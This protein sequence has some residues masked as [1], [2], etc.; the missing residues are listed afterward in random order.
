MS[1]R[2]EDRG[3]KRER[4][5]LLFQMAALL[6]LHGASDSFAQTT[7]DTQ[8]PAPSKEQPVEE[9]V[10]TGFRAGV[11]APSPSAFTSRIEFDDYQGERT[12][13]T[14]LL[15]EQVGVQV[16]RF[17][18]PGDPAEVSIRGSTGAQVVVK[19]D[20]VRMNSVLTGGTDV[21]QLCLGLLE[22]A[23]ITRGGDPIRAGDGSIGGSISFQTRRPSPETVN[24]V[25]VSGGAFGTWE[26]DVQRS[27]QAGPVEY[28]VGYCGFVSDGDYRFAR[29]EIQNPSVP[30][31]P[32]PDLIRINNHRSRQSGNLSL[33][34]DIGPGHLR[35]QDYLTYTSHGVPGLDSGDGPLGGQNP[36]AHAW[37]THNLA[38]LVYSVDDLGGWGNGFEGS[39]HH[40]YQRFAFDDPGVTATDTPRSILTE[41]QTLGAD[42]ENHW[43]FEIWNSSLDWTVIGDFR[44]DMLTD[45]NAPDRARNLGGLATEIE[46]GWL[47]DRIIL[48]PGVRLEWVEGFGETWL[49]TL[50]LVLA[51]LPWLRIKGNLQKTF[52]AP[53]FDELYLPDQ[54]FIRGNPNLQPERAQNADAG[55][56]ARVSQLGPFSDLR[57][58]GGVFLQEVD[59]SILWVNVSPRTIEPFNTGRAQVRGYEISLSFAWTRFFS[60]TANHTGQDAILESTGRPLPGRAQS[61]SL[62]RVRVGEKGR[63]KLIGEMN[64]TGKI[65]VS[66]SGAILLPER[67]VWSASAA[68]NCAEVFPAGWRPPVEALWLYATLNNIS[69]IAV[70]D[71]LFF[72]QPGRNGYLGAQITW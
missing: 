39:L 38:R 53:S 5:R 64:R 23:E 65:P 2:A 59:D 24:R 19:L 49:P 51:P 45:A 31:T 48:V 17:G 32:R 33:G 30:S 47:E 18:G 29:P 16:R 9:I 55:V 22:G 11:L 42:L 10:V 50:G 68:L 34:T 35:F 3:P 13:V 61:E 6:V 7:A 20:G 41:V 40:R 14:E 66:P 56:V 15:S 37:S 46:A 63:W 71:A 67:I 44:R 43:N 62:V 8:K 36:F 69:D 72:P 58:E 54:G 26:A 12:S 1:R 28:G 21:S 25:E 4:S 70:R 60:V 27:G 57:L 52:R